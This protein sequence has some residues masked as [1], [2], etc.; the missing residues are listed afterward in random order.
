MAVAV[1]RLNLPVKDVDPLDQI[2]KGLS[3][4]GQ[5]YGIKEA[6]DKNDLLKDQRGLAKAEKER[7][8]GGVLTKKELL[9][10]QK[11]FEVSE[12]PTE[13]G[14]QYK[15]QEKEGVKDIWLK[16]KKKEEDPLIKAIRMQ[17]IDKMQRD[18]DPNK[19]QNLPKE[20]Q[21]TI[22][23]LSSNRA[24]Q[25]TINNQVDALITQL[26]DPNIPKEQKI[27]S[28]DEQLKLLN[29]VLG[30]DAVGAEEVGRIGKFLSWEPSPTVGKLGF[31]ADIEGYTE[32]LRNLRKRT[33]QSMGMLE[34]QVN[35][36]YGRQPADPSITKNSDNDFPERTPENI[37][38]AKQELIRRR[39]IRSTLPVRK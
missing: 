39:G 8:L 22:E 3:I 18:A 27:A 24:Q 12:A 15:L 34:N 19:F 1:Q 21:V 5:V 26:E 20:K 29:S 23:K 6:I 28:A 13:G 16:P 36:A 10:H 4:A 37:E 32:Q 11:D 2:A 31:G 9:G 17:Q 14:L 33:Q 25:E 7:E 35:S 38:K 30:S